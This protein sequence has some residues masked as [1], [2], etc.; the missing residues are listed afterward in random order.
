MHRE[1]GAHLLDDEGLSMEAVRYAGVPEF[2]IL[3]AQNHRRERNDVAHFI[4]EGMLVN[5]G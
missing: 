4:H 5:T 2:V 1:I 3:K